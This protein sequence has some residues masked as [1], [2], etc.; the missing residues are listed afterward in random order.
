MDIRNNS[1]VYL[2]EKYIVEL[3][4]FFK[5]EEARQMLNI[6]IQDF[7]GFTRTDLALNKE[8][9]LSES[10]ILQL[11]FAVKDLKKHK[12]IQY[13]TGKSEF[14]GF[15][16]QVNE[17]VLIPRPETEELV[18][19]IVLKEKEQSLHILDIGTGS[20][21]IAISLEKKLD[22]PYVTAIDVD[23]KALKLA[24]ANAAQN[25]STVN[26]VKLNILDESAWNELGVFD[27]IVSNPPYVTVND[28]IE[29]HE[30]VLNFEPHLALFVPENDELIFYNK[31]CLFAQK[32][33][34]KN[35]KIYFEIN[36]SKASEI[37]KLLKDENFQLVE[38]HQ[39]YKGKKRFASATKP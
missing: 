19:L 38:V 9:R 37:E 26:F 33:L 31:I 15:I 13:I 30:N 6:L 28:K 7:F 25:N 8:R 16:F 24:S 17:S 39:D 14:L 18:E 29:M 4:S 10:E 20:G 2:R 12:P 3:S 35:G 22:K 32:H 34:A 11:H 36:E 1:L 21:C 23:D 27:I 5:E